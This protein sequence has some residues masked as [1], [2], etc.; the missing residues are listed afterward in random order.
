MSP[1]PI[2]PGT[3]RPMMFVMPPRT[4]CRWTLPQS[5]SAS[6][7]CST[8]F[9]GELPCRGSPVA[10]LQAA[11]T[12]R[13]A[14]ELIISASAS[15]AGTDPRWPGRRPAHQPKPNQTVPVAVL[16][17][18]GGEPARSLASAMPKVLVVDDQPVAIV[19]KQAGSTVSLGQPPSSCSWVGLHQ[20]VAVQVQ[21]RKTKPAVASCQSFSIGANP[22]RLDLLCYRA[23]RQRKLVKTDVCPSRD[24]R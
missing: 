11:I 23:R 4:R 8:R 3:G 1:V 19:G 21:R 16:P 22:G 2:G 17:G 20:L 12:G 7:S 14:D 5:R 15:R 6:A 18:C 24:V 13:K 10:G 9:L